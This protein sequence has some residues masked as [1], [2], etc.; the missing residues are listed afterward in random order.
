MFDDVIR[1]VK[2]LE[3]GVQISIE[4][5]IDNEGYLDRKCPHEECQQEFKVLM[6]DWKEKVS[7]ERVYCPICGY[8]ENS[9]EWNTPEQKRY[10]CDQARNYV[11]DRLN[12]AF[13]SSVRKFNQTQP[14]TG[15]ITM[16]MEYKPGRP[17]VVVPYKVAELM[18]QKFSCEKCN[19]RFSSIGASFFCPACGHNSVEK[20]FQHTIESIEKTLNSIDVIEA[21]LIKN[22]NRDT[23]KDTIRQILETS[24]GKLTGAFQ[25]LTEALF[26][27]LPES[28]QIRL[29]HNV[30]QN[31]DES[32]DLWQQVGCKR[33][34]GM[35]DAQQ[36]YNLKRLFQQRH[37]ISHCD[38]IVDQRYIDETGDTTYKIGQRIV[39]SRN[40]VLIL[41]DIVK[42][43]SR[44]KQQEIM[45]RIM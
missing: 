16:K 6:E 34:E 1:K 9:K 44:A 32:S 22:Q 11:K 7:D 38:G 30:F 23:A 12:K 2:D 13:V 17:N 14:R 10:I 5:P 37:L 31:L 24:L 43:L 28:K 27:K 25:R 4:M 18:Q 19:C 45:Q 3:R 20:D 29:R 39:I 26:N 36:W 35:I 21:T 41:V 40:S 8:S 33:Y 15:W 42:K